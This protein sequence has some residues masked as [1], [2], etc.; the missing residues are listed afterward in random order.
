MEKENRPVEMIS[1]CSA[2]GGLLPVR[3]R[4]EDA[5]HQIQ[6][7][8]IRE[9]VCVKEACYVGV[10]VLFYVCKA[11]IEGQEHLLELKYM[12]KTH[13]WMLFRVIY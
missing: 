13:R 9:I 12:V 3:F 4:Y 6:I 7:A 10:E 1:V 11:R 8:H 5:T 2:D